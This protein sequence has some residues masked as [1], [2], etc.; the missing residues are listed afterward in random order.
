MLGRK[1]MFFVIFGACQT[2]PSTLVVMEERKKHGQNGCTNLL[3]EVA[4]GV[5]I[6]IGEKVENFMLDVIF[7]QMVHQVSP[8][9]L[10]QQLN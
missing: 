5:F 6:S 9:T 2:S 3:F 7:L 10:K 8:I 4:N 1:S